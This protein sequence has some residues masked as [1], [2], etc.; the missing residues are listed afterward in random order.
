MS[1]NS[2][3]ISVASYVLRTIPNRTM[4]IGVQRCGQGPFEDLEVDFTE[5]GPSRVNKYL[6]V[7]VCTFSGW[8]E[9]YPTRTEKVR[10]VT[11]SW[12]KD[13][14]PRY[15]MPLTIGS[16]NGPAFEAEIVAKALGI[17]W[18]LH[19]N[20]R[21]QS[22]GKV[23][24]MNRTLKQAIAKLCQEITLPWTDILPLILL[25]VCCVPRARG[26]LGEI[27]NLEIQKQLQGIGKTVFEVHRWVTDRLSISLGTAIHP[28]KPGDQVWIKDWKKEPLKPTW[29]GPYPVILTTPT[30]LQ[31]AG[32]NTWIYHSWAKAAHQ[33]SDAQPEWKVTSDQKHPL[34][35]TLKRMILVLQN[36]LTKYRGH[37]I[38]NSALPPEGGL[39]TLVPG[40][41][42]RYGL[43]TPNTW[44][45]SCKAR[46]KD[47]K[48]AP[49]RE[50]EATLCRTID[51]GAL[52]SI[53]SKR[54]AQA[55]GQWG[56]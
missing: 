54:E 46:E 13:I 40:Q 34:Q 22:S 23:E 18:N 33:P 45:P 55:T 7:L 41:T 26:D 35:I 20:Y 43:E 28:Y 27:G 24:R 14:I 44:E 51:G 47:R 17:K 32:L 4:L 9:A 50:A 49:Q 19:T 6:L 31:V 39:L 2:Q 15:G 8:V 29:E 48:I 1:Q 11:K 12:L 52:R 21:P 42:I 36:L 38:V 5:I 16:D 10:E 53:A 25:W 3:P 56:D 37:K 30:A